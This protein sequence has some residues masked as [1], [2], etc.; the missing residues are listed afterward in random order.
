MAKTTV[1]PVLSPAQEVA[2]FSRA[3]LRNAIDKIRK[4]E[5]NGNV[6]VNA[7]DRIDRVVLTLFA[8]A[9]DPDDK[10]GVAAAEVL[11]N[12]YYGPVRQEIAVSHDPLEEMTDGELDQELARLL[13]FPRTA[14]K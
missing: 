3:E 10:L 2:P 14:A 11:F 7:M 8:R 6:D 9:A 1:P 13:K 5:A 4:T 12:R